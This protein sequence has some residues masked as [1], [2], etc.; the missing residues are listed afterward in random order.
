MRILHILDHSAPLQSGYVFRTLAILRRQRELGWETGQLTGPKHPSGPAMEEMAAGLLF[1]RTPTGSSLLNRAPI[2][3]Q[4]A[5]I[6]ALRQRILALAEIFKPDLLHAHSP[7]LNG[8]AALLAGARLGIPVVYEVRAFWE[9]AAASHGTGRAWGARYRLTRALETHVLKKAHAVTVICEGLRR[10]VIAR[11]IDAAKVTT[12]PN[13]VEAQAFATPPATLP[14]L[15]HI[16]RNGREV[17]GYIGSF[18]AYE[19]LSLLLD[20]LPA[21]CARRPRAMLLLVGGGPEERRL[22]QQVQRMGLAE[23]V[24]FTGRTPPEMASGYYALTDLLIYPRLPM[25]LTH[26]VTP[27]KPLEAMAAKRLVLASDVEGHKELITHGATGFLFPA[28]DVN[29]L[30]NTVAELLENR[31]PW[32]SVIRRAE[33][34]V[35]N[36]R[37]W[38]ASVDRYQT[39][40]HTLLDTR[41]EPI[42]PDWQPTRKTP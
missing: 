2:L 6:T 34:F 25:R 5:V 30:A 22:R 23:R 17:L 27:L 36:T 21:I 31:A 13:A 7:V 29:A 14:T 39:V 8:L 41:R 35:H 33:Q 11:G 16:D 12:I 15:P 28:N 40:Y 20:A 19:G 24:C 4:V 26:L 1:H 3:R 38:S 42:A 37:T 32:E 18:Y 9:D 10:D